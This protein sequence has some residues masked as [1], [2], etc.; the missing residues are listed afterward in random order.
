MF[1]LMVSSY[2]MNTF[3]KTRAGIFFSAG[4]ISGLGLLAAV[5]VTGCGGDK[6][7]ALVAPPPPPAQPGVSLAPAADAA[8][9][10]TVGNSAD[11]APNVT[12]AAGPGAAA[13]VPVDQFKGMTPQQI[14]DFKAE[15]TPETH[16]M[17]LSPL[18]EAVTGFMAE[19]RRA[20]ANQEEMVKA[21]YLA[22]V[23]QAPKGKR[24][25]INPQTG[26]VTVE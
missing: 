19:Y 6:D 12:A 20:P 5:F 1:M 18:M 22:K 3:M 4:L 7:D 26:E 25:V 11:G 21:R 15:T 2:S 8:A 10:P 17:N 24:Y 9:T 13:G 23:L 16:D 14:A